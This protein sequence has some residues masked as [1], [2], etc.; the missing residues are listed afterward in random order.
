MKIKK[1]HINRMPGFPQ[2]VKGFGKL[3]GN[4]NIVAGANGSGKRSTARVI[5]KLIWWNAK[6]TGYQVDAEV[7]VNDEL[8]HIEIDSQS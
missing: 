4:I 6:T 1:L 8:N 2:G 7:V 5:Q 3:A